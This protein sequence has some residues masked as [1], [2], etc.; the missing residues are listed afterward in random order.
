MGCTTCGD[1]LRRCD[2]S[3]LVMLKVKE[4]SEIAAPSRQFVELA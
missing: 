2:P 3:L 1:R 4:A